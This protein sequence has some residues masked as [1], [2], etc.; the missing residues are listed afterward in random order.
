MSHVY[1]LWIVILSIAV[2]S[3]CA[4]QKMPGMKIGKPYAIDGKTYYP[5]YEPG[6]DRTGI[7]SWYGPGFHGKYTASGE[8]FDQYDLTAAHTTLPMPSLVRVT[9]LSN[10]RS[11]VVRINDRGPFKDNRIIDLSKKAAEKLGIKGVSKVRVQFLEE[12]TQQYI[13]AV[14]ANDGRII[15]MAEYNG[16]IE[17]RVFA[18]TAEEREVT[19]EDPAP[20]II[21]VEHDDIARGENTTETLPMPKAAEP[22]ASREVTLFT[23]PRSGFMGEPAA[24]KTEENPSIPF[25]NEKLPRQAKGDHEEEAGLYTIQAG[26]FSSEHNAYSLA[27]KISTIATPLVE[28]ITHQGKAAWRVRA[29]SFPSKNSALNMLKHIHATGVRDARVVR[30]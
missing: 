4:E 26:I 21:S 9:H 6:Y 24:L 30:K 23:T 16:E 11:L 22:R 17:E 3:G 1:G 12:E 5:G 27:E 15:P 7:A 8:L 18:D 29:G 13:A 28:N 19:M 20:P 14:K 2:L 10:G 25:S